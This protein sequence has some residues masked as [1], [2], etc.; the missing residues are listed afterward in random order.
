MIINKPTYWEEIPTNDYAENLEPG[1]H[2]LQILSAEER[3][4]QGANGPWHGLLI[5]FD[6]HS[7]DYQ[8]GA[9][10]AKYEYNKGFRDDAPWPASGSKMIYLPQDKPESGR[11]L[12]A[13]ID[14]L[15]ASNAGF[16]YDWAKDFIAQIKGKIIGGVFRNEEFD[17]NGKTGFTPKLL[18]F[19]NA[20]DVPNA[21]KP[22]PKYLNEDSKV[23]AKGPEAQGEELPGDDPSFL[24][25][26][27]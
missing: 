22:E 20:D 25:F 5:F 8:A 2:Y 26:D 11:S 12:K 21:K 4:G 16:K 9:I 19:I 7:T 15:E 17:Y 24:P 1:G 13:F 3:Q 23:Q 14:A 27:L 10:K 18:Y 6:C